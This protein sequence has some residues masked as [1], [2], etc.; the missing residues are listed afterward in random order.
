MNTRSAIFGT[1]TLVV[2]LTAGAAQ[3]LSGS[4]TVTSDDIVDGTITHA[5]IKAN[6]I[7]GSRFLDNSVTGGKILDNTITG[8]D[9]N[10]STLAIHKI[11]TT[12]IAGDGTKLDGDATSAERLST[13]LY[14]VVFDFNVRPC[15]AHVNTGR[16]R[17]NA[18]FN[19]R[20]TFEVSP[21]TEDPNTVRVGISNEFGA[22]DA[23]PPVNSD[24]MLTLI[25][26]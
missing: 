16:V 22:T 19:Y 21:Y 6:S 13:G 10:E 17:A 12:R 24:F 7:G 15:S 9:V 1:T 3:S 14:N 2:L 5:D 20:A 8:A 26:P 11:R 18:A 25:C 23:A 4:N